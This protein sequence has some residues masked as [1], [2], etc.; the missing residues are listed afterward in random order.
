MYATLEAH[1]DIILASEILVVCLV[2]NLTHMMIALGQTLGPKS[3]SIN[4]FLAAMP[5]V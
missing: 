1:P 2:Q 4:G 5:L 3:L